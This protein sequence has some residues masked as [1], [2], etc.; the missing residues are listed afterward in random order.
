MKQLHKPHGLK[1]R[2]L[3]AVLIIT[4]V[5][6]PFLSG[7]LGG[8]LSALLL[9]YTMIVIVMSLPLPKWWVV[10]YVAIAISA[11]TIQ[12][13]ASMGWRDNSVQSLSLLPQA[14]FV[15]YFGAA[16]Y[17]IGRDIFT[18]RTVT[19]DTVRGG[20]S[21]YFMIG[22]L[23]AFLYGMVATL[24]IDAFS[25]PLLIDDSYL[26][27]FHFS[28]TTLTT[29]GYGD[30]VPIS[31]VALVLTNLEAITGQ[32]YSTVFIAILVGGYLSQSPDR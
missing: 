9:M 32:M 1:Y 2:Q 30:I 14:I 7:S 3:L 22:Y 10:G 16:I 20:I 15:L 26:R 21:I 17:W 11:F 13:S 8:I 18:T 24:N 5:A 31:D 19:A 29:L 25:Q 27:V 4:F 23:W 12:L 28:F 6:T